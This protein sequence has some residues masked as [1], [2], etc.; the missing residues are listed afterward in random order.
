LT[1][2]VAPLTTS[3]NSKAGAA[4]P[5]GSIVEAVRTMMEKC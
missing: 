2:I 4:V 5:R 3:G 1:E